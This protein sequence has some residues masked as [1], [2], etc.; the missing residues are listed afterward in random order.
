[1]V[2][3]ALNY[4]VVVAGNGALGLSLGLVLAR[5]GLRVAVVGRADRPYAASAAAGAMNGCFGEVTPHL[6]RSPHG[7]LKLAM[8]FQATGLW[9]AW[10]EGLLEE[11]DETAIRTADGT[12]VILNTVGIHEIDTEGFRAIRSALD[13]YKE[14]YE[15]LDPADV[16][17]L[18]PAPTARPLQAM[19]IP[20]EHAVDAPALLRALSTAFT[21]NG[22]TLVDDLVA[23]VRLADG[24]ADGVRLES[25]T[26]LSAGHVALAT[27]AAT[28]KLLECLPEEIRHRIPAIVAGRGV[29]L[30]VRTMD[31]TIPR[32]VIRT[33][34]R[35]FACGLHVVPRQDGVLYLGATNEV[36][37]QVGTTAAIGEL[38]LL[39]SG[40]SQMH[41]DLVN[42]WVERIMVGNRPVPLDGFPLLGEVGIDGLW[43]MTGTYRD[44]L[45]QSPLL[46]AEMAA[47]ILGEPRD[48]ELDVFTPVR[49][50]IQSMTREECLEM[51]VRHTLGSGYEHEWRL[52]DDWPPMIEKHFR[53]AFGRS[54]EEVDPEFVPP[55][56][57]FIFADDHIHAALRTYYAAHRGASGR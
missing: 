20:G 12:V 13:E 14:P 55:P 11:S 17:W 19:F 40:A 25:G 53:S 34:N 16:P 38:N 6:L 10:Q 31:G 57:M 30:M 33:P 9:D 42:G 54:L 26:T 48:K 8:D 18:H 28:T 35:A 22:G 32:T 21:R 46:A 1:M 5:R 27:G 36:E 2:D 41:D 51:A 4:D 43:L 45:H 23:E 44:G 29:A 50:P 52:P 47:R 15:D 56:E 24:R 7:R 3:A 37:S 39:L 49:P